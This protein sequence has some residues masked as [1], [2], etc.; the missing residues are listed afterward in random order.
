MWVNFIQPTE[1]LKTGKCWGRENLS[2]LIVFELDIGL[3]SS[4][5]AWTG[6]YIISS[7]GAPACKSWDFSKSWGFYTCMSQFLSS[8]PFIIYLFIIYLFFF[9][10]LSLSLSLFFFFF[11]LFRATP[12]ACVSSQVRGWIGAAAASLYHS[13]SN[14]RSKP[15]PGPTPQL[16]ATP[17]P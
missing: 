10:F 17:D 16:T 1:D 15:C 11:C 9:L 13:H 8:Y 12:T 4:H 14:A 7:S 3:L 5:L 2:L 6:I